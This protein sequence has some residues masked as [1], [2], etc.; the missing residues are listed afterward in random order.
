MVAMATSPQVISQPT[1]HTPPSE[2]DGSEDYVPIVAGVAGGVALIVL[3][4]LLVLCGGKIWFRKKK[5]GRV[6]VCLCV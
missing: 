2:D 5:T 4:F 3:V 1:P 6:D